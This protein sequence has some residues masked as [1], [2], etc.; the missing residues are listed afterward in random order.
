MLLPDASYQSLVMF[1][2]PVNAILTLQVV[3]LPPPSW[4][5]KPV[6]QSTAHQLN[7]F[8]HLDFEFH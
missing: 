3:S 1:S 6:N 8:I 5:V 7:K 4:S 2:F